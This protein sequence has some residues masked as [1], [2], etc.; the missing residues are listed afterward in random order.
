ME[1][2]GAIMITSIIENKVD[3]HPHVLPTPNPEEA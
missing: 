2:K 3:I 1:D